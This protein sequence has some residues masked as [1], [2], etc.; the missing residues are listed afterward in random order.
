LLDITQTNG[1]TT[2]FKEEIWILKR[3]KKSIGGV[4]MEHSYAAWIVVNLKASV[5]VKTENAMGRF[6]FGNKIMDLKPTTNPKCTI[7]ISIVVDVVDDPIVDGKD[8]I[9]VIGKV[10]CIE[11]QEMAFEVDKDSSE[12][13]LQELVDSLTS[14]VAFKIAERIKTRLYSKPIVVFDDLDTPKP[15][16]GDIRSSDIKNEATNSIHRGQSQT[17]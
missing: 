2:V 9:V 12:E 7:P 10:G 15:N 13:D 5:R 14:D 8:S 11:C 1:D 17:S 6:I 16:L 3:K 4:K